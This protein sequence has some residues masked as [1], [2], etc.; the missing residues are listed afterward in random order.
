VPSNLTTAVRAALRVAP[1]SLSTL[2]QAAGVSVSTLRRLRRGEQ[3]A[4]PEVA[5]ALAR[6]LARWGTRCTRAGRRLRAAGRR[7]RGT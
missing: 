7:G 4:S 5:R 1:A 6:V 2:A 3:G